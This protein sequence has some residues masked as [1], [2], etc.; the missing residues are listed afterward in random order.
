MAAHDLVLITQ[1]F[2]RF[3]PRNKCYFCESYCTPLIYQ[4]K[5]FYHLNRR[6]IDRE[7]PLLH[8]H[9]EN[10]NLKV[11]KEEIR[12]AA[13]GILFLVGIFTIILSGGLNNFN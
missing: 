11:W 2:T 9:L 13:A 5:E 8:L 7:K 1:S 3:R 12:P 4:K 10:P 6:K